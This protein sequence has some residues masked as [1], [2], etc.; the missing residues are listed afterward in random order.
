MWIILETEWSTIA[1]AK[2]KINLN[3]KKISAVGDGWISTIM[4]IKKSFDKQS[5][6]V[7]FLYVKM[8]RT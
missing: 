6:Y 1:H 5:I 2:N 8:V 7:Y 3:I 4:H